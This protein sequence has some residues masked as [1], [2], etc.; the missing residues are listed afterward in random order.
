VWDWHVWWEEGLD[1]G[2]CL[3]RREIDVDGV[4]GVAGGFGG[5]ERCVGEW[6]TESKVVGK[7]IRSTSAVESKQVARLGMKS[8]TGAEDDD[9]QTFQEFDNFGE[10][11]GFDLVM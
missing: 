3:G 4:E 7:D 2:A 8:Q 5:V 9:V 1:V 11:C 10:V 6:G